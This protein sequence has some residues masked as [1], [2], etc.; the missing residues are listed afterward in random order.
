MVVV[1]KRVTASEEQHCRE[2]NSEMDCWGEVEATRD[3]WA[4][5]PDHNNTNIGRISHEE[6]TTYSD[7]SSDEVKTKHFGSSETRVWRCQEE[8]TTALQG[9]N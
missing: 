9:G 4:R 3:G 8:N 1:V 2:V 6:L 5:C 7:K